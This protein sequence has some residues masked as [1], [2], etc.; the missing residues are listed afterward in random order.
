MDALDRRL[1]FLVARDGKCMPLIYCCATA[2][3]KLR[4]K[5]ID[6]DQEQKLYNET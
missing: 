2:C 3:A 6:L 5:V 1:G 4:R